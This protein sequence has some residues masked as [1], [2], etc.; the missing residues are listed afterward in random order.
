[1][2]YEHVLI[3]RRDGRGRDPFFVL[4]QHCAVVAEEGVQ[5]YM[6]IETSVEP[7]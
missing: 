6:L 2:L 1:M 3:Q 7:V 5:G 4:G